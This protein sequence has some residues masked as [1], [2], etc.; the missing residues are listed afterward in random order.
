MPE[1]GSREALL[2]AD[3]NAEMI[4]HIDRHPRVRDLALFVGNPGD[5]V[6]EDFGPGLP[7]IR[8]WTEA[9]YSFPGY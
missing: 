3:Y 1:T 2:T 5:I 6:D 7:P 4:E 9:H 8:A